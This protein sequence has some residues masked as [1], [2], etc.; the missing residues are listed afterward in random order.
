V[1]VILAL[2]RVSKSFG[3]VVIAED[4]D[5]KVAE[6]EA[7]GMLGPNGAGKTTLFGVISGMIAPNAGRVVFAGMDVTR[8]SPVKRCRLGIA[9]SFQI[10]QP[11]GGMTVF[12]NLVVAG[13]FA[14]GRR[15]RDVYDWSAQV[16]DD[17]GLGDKANV[18]AGTLTLLDRKR[19][20]LARALATR[21]RLLLLDEVAGGLSEA[22]C[23]TLVDLIRRIRASGIS[24]IW[25]EH[26]VHALLAAVD[27]IVVL[28]G[29]SLIADDRPAAAIRHPKVVEIYMGIPAD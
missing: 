19:L 27:R 6:G 17:C 10:P 26:V 9:R 22:E 16:L 15:E 11:F 21:P 28:A 13:A 23:E 29:G 8:L 20:E 5:L 24:L 25:I 18:K 1:S 4:L 7:L 2:E 14:K 12:E 3:A